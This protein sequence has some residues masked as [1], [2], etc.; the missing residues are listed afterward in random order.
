MKRILIFCSLFFVTILT[1]ANTCPSPPKGFIF[2][3]AAWGNH[4]DPTSQVRCHYYYSADESIQREIWT[5]EWYTEADFI[6]YPQWYSSDHYYYLCT[7]H[8][9][10]V[11][12]C[13]FGKK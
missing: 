5:A 2:R 7:S 10:N 1:Y 12:E 8:A 3:V 11:N 13:P 4:V 9:T 6:G